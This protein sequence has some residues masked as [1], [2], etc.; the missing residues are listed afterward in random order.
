VKEVSYV[1]AE[2]VSNEQ[3]VAEF[4][5]RAGFHAL[6]RRPVD[7]AGVGEG[8]LRHVLVQ[9]PYPDAVADSPA[10]FENPLGL[11]G[12]HLA[13]LLPTMIICQQQNCGI[14]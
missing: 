14:L 5:L 1:H 7:A 13:N 9:P 3:H 8:F 12:W 11:I 2:S 4:H 6:D 10:G